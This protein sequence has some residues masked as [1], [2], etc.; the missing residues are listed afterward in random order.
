MHCEM[1][2]SDLKL[3]L[4]DE[5]HPL[6]YKIK[7]R[8]P[9]FAPS[10]A[11]LQPRKVGGFFKRVL[12]RRKPEYEGWGPIPSR[13]IIP[14]P[15]NEGLSL[16]PPGVIIPR[17]GDEGWSPVLPGLPPSI[18]PPQPRVQKAAGLFNRVLESLNMRVP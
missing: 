12:L 8:E 5:S 6:V 7:H 17:P 11:P 15:G 16:F 18:G 9:V 2:N 14:R 10:I 4:H 1:C 3:D 13:G